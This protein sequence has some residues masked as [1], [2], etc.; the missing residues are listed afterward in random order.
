MGGCGSVWVCVGGWVVVGVGVWVWVR[1]CVIKWNTG[2]LT[3]YVHKCVAS[4]L[5]S[6]KQAPSLVFVSSLLLAL[7]QVCRNTV[8]PRCA[9]TVRVTVIVLCV[10]QSV[11]V[12]AL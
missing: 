12:S 3:N 7:G 1:V 4:L 8:N 6:E 5:P 2:H 9:C 10:C 11:C